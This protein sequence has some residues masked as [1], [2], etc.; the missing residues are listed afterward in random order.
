M[1][2]FLVQILEANNL[3]LYST[4]VNGDET[5][6]II[7][8]NIHGEGPIERNIE[9]SVSQITIDPRITHTFWCA[10]DKMII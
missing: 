6:V 8:A 4:E 5:E 3:H 9:R 10:L 1:R 2:A 7:I